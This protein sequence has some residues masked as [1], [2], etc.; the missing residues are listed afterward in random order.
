LTQQFNYFGNREDEVIIYESLVSE[1]GEIFLMPQRGSLDDMSPK[2]IKS[3]ED[4]YAVNLKD[5]MVLTTVEHINLLLLDEVMDGIF[6]VD[7]RKSPCL[8]FSPSKDL[9]QEVVKVGRIAYFYE[10]DE[11]LKKK[12]KRLF[13]M[14]KRNS[15]NIEKSN[16]WIL[17]MLLVKKRD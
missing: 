17:P 16:F 15:Q 14:L 7:Y 11:N 4:L 9:S 8:E 3:V 6:S 13:K 5:M 2:P 1:L 10:N 12:V